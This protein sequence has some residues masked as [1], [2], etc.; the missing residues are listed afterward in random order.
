MC[1]SRAGKSHGC[2]AGDV[3]EMFHHFMSIRGLIHDDRVAPRCDMDNGE[4][5]WPKN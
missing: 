5:E 1:Q 3:I 2:R 4:S